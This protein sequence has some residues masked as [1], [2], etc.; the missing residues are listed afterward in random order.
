MD[1]ID[2]CIPLHV[3]I[4][5]SIRPSSTRDRTVIEGQS[6]NSGTGRVLLVFA[7]CF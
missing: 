4:Y 7:E 3:I 6:V 5:S 1:Q 2:W